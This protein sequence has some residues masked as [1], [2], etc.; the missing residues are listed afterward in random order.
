MAPQQYYI[1]LLG[2][3]FLHLTKQIFAACPEKCRCEP[4]F[5]DCTNAGLSTIPWDLPDPVG[6]HTL[7]LQGNK[8][9]ALV[10]EIVSYSNLQVLDLSYNN[11][12]RIED[13]VFR[14]LVN[15]KTLRLTGNELD[16]ITSQT[17]KGLTS[18]QVLD[19]SENDISNIQE[20]PFTDL[21]K[22][23]EL[24]LSRNSIS[25]VSPIAFL[26]LVSLRSLA[27]DNNKLE[28]LLQESL[29]HA[30]NLHYL[31]LNNN[32]MKQ[33]PSGTFADLKV[34][35]TLNLDGNDIGMISETAF[36]D[37]FDNHLKILSLQNNDLSAVPTDALLRLKSIRTI[38]LS[39]NPIVVIDPD[40]FKG[41][42]QLESV[43]IDSMPEMEVIRA[44]SFSALQ[45][46]KSV[47]IHSN[48][49]LRSIEQDAFLGSGNLK[50]VDMHSTGLT[51]LHSGL[52][53]WEKM[54]HLDLRFNKWHCDCHLQ[55]L[56]GVLH[57]LTNK[58]LASQV[59]CSSPY[60]LE[61]KA[62]VGLDSDHFQCDVQVKKLQEEVFEEK[63]VIGIIAG[64][65]CILLVITI[66]LM[67][68]SR[69]TSCGMGQNPAR[70]RIQRSMGNGRVV[71]STDVE[72]DSDD[73]VNITDDG[74]EQHNDEQSNDN[75]VEV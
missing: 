11:M 31:M 30:S 39:G 18:L 59:F 58:T 70:Y 51:T 2:I 64:V 66:A 5:I 7:R 35:Q 29:G 42:Q 61:S 65:S 15:L 13:N 47:S 45:S 14:S 26:G 46:L 37:E 19:L 71:R 60:N 3:L 23:Q 40:A 56:P 52:F 63:I 73:R 8:I 49:K 33:I 38:V 74:E 48:P 36:G 44:Y 57:S 4:G 50:H 55:F 41:L 9:H 25:T 54:Q 10:A 62:I 43:S 24:D 1:W 32:D 67:Y 69:Y 28:G 75:E 68:R 21:Q 6:L 22:L 16:T 34:L 27:L 20:S 53:T 72:N 12:N 17:F